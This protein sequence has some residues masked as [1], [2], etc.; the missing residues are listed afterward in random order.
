MYL[1]GR[2]IPD[3]HKLLE[4]K[5]I[6]QALFELIEEKD[7]YSPLL[8]INHQDHFLSLSN[9]N[10]YVFL[11][12]LVTPQI[13]TKVCDYCKYI[14]NRKTILVQLENYVEIPL[15]EHQFCVRLKDIIQQ[16]E[17]NGIKKDNLFLHLLGEIQ[18]E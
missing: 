14:F 15:F 13:V 3:L 16:A 8:V 17:Q 9:E 10:Y 7:N 12:P 5:F 2:L 11:L 6:Q 4:T 18:V 1:T